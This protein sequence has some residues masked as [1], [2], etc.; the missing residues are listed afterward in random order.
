[1]SDHLLYSAKT[2]LG[3]VKNIIFLI[4]CYIV[5]KI[6]KK[7]FDIFIKL[8]FFIFIFTSL[9]TILQYLIGKDIFGYTKSH[10]Y[11][12]LSGPFDDEL[13]VGSFLSKILFISILYFLLNFKKKYYDLIFITFAVLVIF[14]TK[15][16]SA[17]IMA[18]LA[19][20]M[21]VFLRID[22]FKYKIISLFLF[23]LFIIISFTAVPIL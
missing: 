18:I 3:L 17:I 10:S 15:E 20:F 19:S 7:I 14:L 12:R 5:F 13:I 6:D 8:V 4:G 1:M 21:Y 23:A 2:S 16:R 22:K 9:D 11:G